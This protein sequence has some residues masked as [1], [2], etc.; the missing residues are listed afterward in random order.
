MPEIVNVNGPMKII[1]QVYA[2][3]LL[4]LG[5]VPTTTVL[6]MGKVFFLTLYFFFLAYRLLY[7]PPIFCSIPSLFNFACQYVPKL[8]RD[9]IEHHTGG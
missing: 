6:L 4:L 8:K 1:V 3:Y 7:Y 9:G 5:Q 2:Q